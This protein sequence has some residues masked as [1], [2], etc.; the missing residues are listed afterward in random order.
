M[1]KRNFSFSLFLLFICLISFI[2]IITIA[3]DKSNAKTMEHLEVKNEETDFLN[4]SVSQYPCNDLKIES[5]ALDSLFDQIVK[6]YEE[7]I[8]FIQKI[9]TSQ[10]LWNKTTAANIA[11]IFPSGEPSEY[12][13][14]QTICH[15]TFLLNEIRARRLFLNTW[16][17]GV[18]EGDV[19]RG[20]RELRK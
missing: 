14:S 16:M 11:A 2:G 5:L 3:S 6:R 12:G 1:K 13:S 10:E 8:A 18:P 9:K 15:C 19:C 17:E 7:D 4:H 20:S